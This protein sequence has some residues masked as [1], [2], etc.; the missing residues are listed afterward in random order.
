[1]GQNSLEQSEVME[2]NSTDIKKIPQLLSTL[3]QKTKNLVL[4]IPIFTLILGSAFSIYV[5]RDLNRR[6][7]NDLKAESAQRSREIINQLDLLLSNSVLRIQSYEEYIGTRSGDFTKDRS[8][9]SQSLRY[10]I[11]QR[12]SIFS[13]KGL[14]RNG[15]LRMKMITRL[16]TSNSTL[17]PI[18]NKTIT[19]EYLILGIQKMVAGK[20]YSRVIL[21]EVSGASRLSL[22]LK[23]RVRDDLI[24]IFTAPLVSIF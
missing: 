12:F 7:S 20:E 17:A 1:M 11:F 5:Y 23:T 15:M 10:T 9:L 6:E 18:K 24:F 13:V 16:D 22:V 8:F 4:W 14:D 21:H 19:S 2:N 3:F